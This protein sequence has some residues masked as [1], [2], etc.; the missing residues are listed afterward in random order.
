[1]EN[2]ATSSDRYVFIS[3]KSEE[4][5]LADRIKSFLELHGFKWWMAP[6]S[7]NQVG[8]QDYSDDIYSAIRGCSCLIFA[9]S[10]RALASKW[11]KREVGYA[12]ERNKPIIPFV[13]SPV[14]EKDQEN[15]SLFITL[16]LEKQILN[17]DGS[18]DM[19]KVLMP[20][21]QR[22][23]GCS[24]WLERSH[25]QK[26]ETNGVGTT[27]NCFKKIS[28]HGAERTISPVPSSLKNWT[29]TSQATL[30]DDITFGPTRR[31]TKG[32]LILGRYEVLLELGQ[33]GMGI[34]YKCLDNVGGVVVAVKSL[35]PVISRDS[36]YKND[37]CGNFRLV[38]E[39]RHPNIVG[40]RSLETDSAT[41]DYYLV[42]DFAPGKSLRA[43]AKEHRKHL[44]GTFEIVAELASALDYAH[45]RGVM[46]RDVKPENVTID[47]DGHAHLFDFSIAKQIPTNKRRD[48]HVV[49]S[50][51]GTPSYMAPE[52][53]SGQPQNAA[54]DQYSL[55]VLAYELIAGH[56][57]FDATNSAALAK[58]VL[59]H[60]VPVIQ[61]APAHV[62]AALKR[63][64]AKKPA[65]RFASCK[66]FAEALKGKDTRNKLMM[67]GL[68]ILGL[69]LVP[70]L[71]G[72]GGKNES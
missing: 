28:I 38:S 20:Y 55:G 72:Y 4:K 62:N 69:G 56:L 18:W 7:L 29:I 8:T 31:L 58:K 19:E 21:L 64:L 57:P 10:S 34:V 37:V 23:F 43:W 24:G 50:T 63:A 30:L 16:K 66:G 67:A 59:R 2:N 54:T 45:S 15:N 12:D 25:R 53:W 52:Q 14:L 40:I 42:M 6:D 41:G 68:R 22:T 46:H 47:D 60:Q 48:G 9:V 5:E 13:V 44:Q 70:P 11:V 39:L 49:C 65:E 61:Y 32:D 36:T 27:D 71:L 26:M 3:Y 35:F 17:G 1:M 33:G 51:G